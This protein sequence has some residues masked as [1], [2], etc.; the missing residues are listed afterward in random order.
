[1]ILAYSQVYAR[2]LDQ[3]LKALRN[4]LSDNQS[5][6]LFDEFLAKYEFGRAV[7]ALCD[8][9]LEPNTQTVTRDE[10]HEIISLHFAVRSQDD[11]VKR[12]MEKFGFRESSA[13]NG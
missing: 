13:G 11:C 4:L 12:L 1:V 10:L 8:F 2:D 3:R 9:L 5:L 6:K 7:H